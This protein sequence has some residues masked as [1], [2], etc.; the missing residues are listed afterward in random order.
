MT[1]QQLKK[2]LKQLKEQNKQ[3]EEEEQLHK[4]IKK[5]QQKQFKKT[6]IGKIINFVDKWTK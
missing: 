4:A 1:N 6:R 2:K 5:E 3:I